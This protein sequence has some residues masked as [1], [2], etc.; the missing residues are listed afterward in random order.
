MA[1][2]TT[3][4]T[5]SAR[6]AQA[7]SEL[8]KVGKEFEGLG[9]DARQGAAAISSNFSRART[10]IKSLSDE[11]ATTKRQLVGFFTATFGVQFFRGL[12]EVADRMTLVDARLR[13]ATKSQEEFAAA[14]KGTLDIARR[15]GQPLT[16]V[17]DLYSRIA[18]SVRELGGA[19]EE[20][21]GITETINK[22]IVVSGRAAS[23]SAAGIQQLVQGF[24]G[25]VLRGEE[26]NSVMENTPRVA[27]LIA[28]GLRVPIGALRQ[29]AEEGQL[30]ADVVTKAI[31]SQADAIEREFAQMP[32]TIGRA[33]QNLR[34]EFE[35]FV[36][37]T[38]KATGASRDFAGAVQFLAQN[39]NTLASAI[40]TLGKA[41]A[42]AFGGVL[43][44]R[45]AAGLQSIAGGVRAVNFSLVAFAGSAALQK[46]I[47]LGAGARGGVIGLLLFGGLS[48]ATLVGET[49]LVRGALGRLIDRAGLGADPFESLTAQLERVNKAI[50]QTPEGSRGALEQ[51]QRALRAE[52]AERNK[53][54]RAGAAERPEPLAN[55]RRPGSQGGAITTQVNTDPKKRI[56]ATEAAFERDRAAAEKIAKTTKTKGS[57]K[58][59]EDTRRES[60][61]ALVQAQEKEAAT[62]GLS[63]RALA[64]Y[65]A[66]QLGAGKKEKDRINIAFAAIEAEERKQ[67]AIERATE[68]RELHLQLLAEEEEELQAVGEARKRDA[69][70]I[71]QQIDPFRTL[72]QER[73]RA[74]ELF[75]LKAIDPGEFAQAS[76]NI[77]ERIKEVQTDLDR[78]KN[79]FGE[80][81]IQAA[82]NIQTTLADFLFDPFKDGLKGMLDSF[83]QTLRRMAAEALAAQLGKKLFG[84][85]DKGGSLG[86]IAGKALEFLAGV[87]HDGGVVGAGG[88]RRRVPALAFSG[89]PRF[90]AGG[91][92]GLSADE[93]PAVLQRGE[94]VLTRDDPRHRANGGGV[95]VNMTINNPQDANSII[96]SRSQIEAAVRSAAERGIRNS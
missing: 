55:I 67:Q 6:A 83:E 24:D 47:T 21:L 33:F 64:L 40:A 87:F 8:A 16:D 39:L 42:F 20:A 26:F 46:I 35:Q 76:A 70:A 74:G 22:A 11:L 85:I 38:D 54:A 25:G 31:S 72:N 48:A 96:R 94:E 44:G 34:T 81:A 15:T 9:A 91:I 78:A 75:K 93:V 82:R 92:L 69:E 58:S 18:R 71:R 60:L 13:L 84:D 77:R 4:I 49:E 86:G 41:L 5:I 51:Q 7:L 95:V 14:Q 79:Q 28:D 27:Q 59:D 68:D 63:G 30:T 29:M 89:A 50:A 10:G 23:T 56:A 37:N 19:Q 80:F 62:L 57:G 43:L 36:G 2:L 32:L 45:A 3:R 88:T 90:H 12:G 65:E 73:A 66:R 52:I 17:A 61:A 53:I 1:E